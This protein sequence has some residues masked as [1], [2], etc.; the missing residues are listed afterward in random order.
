MPNLYYFDCIVNPPHRPIQK[1]KVG[2]PWA[3]RVLHMGCP[4]TQWAAQWTGAAHC[5]CK[6]IIISAHGLHMGSSVGR[7]CQLTFK[8][9]TISDHGQL[10][11]LDYI[12][13]S[14]VGSSNLITEKVVGSGQLQHRFSSC[15]WVITT[16]YWLM[17]LG[18]IYIVRKSDSK[19]VSQQKT[20]NCVVMLEAGIWK[21]WIELT[22]KM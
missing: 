7:S 20:S 4:L 10:R 6:L 21:Y 12:V 5:L 18:K 11:L 13:G 8:F 15:L 1:W 2:C 22:T 14:S 17:H 9:I 16:Q 19:A 3:A